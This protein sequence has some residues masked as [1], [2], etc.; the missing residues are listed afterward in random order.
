MGQP[1]ND[2]NAAVRKFLAKESHGARQYEYRAHRAHA[3]YHGADAGGADLSR[4]FLR[5]AKM[6]LV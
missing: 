2:A 3:E 5:L 6:R 4:F 1:F